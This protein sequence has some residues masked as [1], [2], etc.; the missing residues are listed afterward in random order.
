MKIFSKIGLGC[1]LILGVATTVV[2]AENLTEVRNAFFPPVPDNWTQK[3]EN[4]TV[5]YSAPVLKQGEAPL[6]IIRLTYS[7]ATAEKTAENLIDDFIKLKHCENKQQIGKDFYM[8][9]CKLAKVDAIFVGEVNNMYR[10][11]VQG[12]YTTEAKNIVNKYLND[13]VKGKRTFKDRT[14]ADKIAGDEQSSSS[15]IKG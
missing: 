4:N 11:E 9:S 8:T 7:R 6:S 15:A 12:V 1:C 3:I 10:I 14:V 2:N 13:I 5:I